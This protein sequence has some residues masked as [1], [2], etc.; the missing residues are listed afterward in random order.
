MQQTF[1][2]GKALSAVLII[3]LSGLYEAADHSVLLCII[4]TTE[5][6]KN[7]YI[8]MLGKEGLKHII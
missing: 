1:P 7:K 5:Q 3:F 4:G 2:M 6:G 8:L